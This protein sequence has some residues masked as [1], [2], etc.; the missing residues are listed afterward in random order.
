[1]TLV[2]LGFAAGPATAQDAPPAAPPPATTRVETRAVRPGEFM[3]IEPP[4]TAPSVPPLEIPG[5]LAP[6]AP[7]GR[8]TLTPS[9]GV[10]LEYDDNIFRN[11]DNKESDLI[12]G[13]SPGIALFINQPRYQIRASYGFTA[14]VYADHSELNEAFAQ[15]SLSAEGLYLLDPGLTL[16]LSNRFLY[17]TRGRDLGG[18]EDLQ[19]TSRRPVLTNRLEPA[20][21][22][23][24]R[25][26]T[27]LQLSG[28][29]TIQRIEAET[30]D[31]TIGED[32]AGARDSDSYRI[33]L[34]VTHTFRPRLRGTAGYEFAF[35]DTEE[36]PEVFTHTP[37][38]GLAYDF[39]RALRG[40]VSAGPEFVIR[41]SDTTVGLA[42][43]ASLVHAFR[44]GA[45]SAAYDQ[46]TRAQGGTGGPGRT[47]AVTASVLVTQWVRG[48]SLSLTPRYSLSDETGADRETRTLSVSLDASYEIWRNV[49][50]F[51]TYSFL[52]QRN[53]G[54][55]VRDVDQ[56]RVLLGIRYGYPISFD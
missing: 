49:S 15:Q 47:H 38:A 55:A 1:M 22:W 30:D 25:P 45:I 13:F 10:S 5:L 35:L 32:D 20:L 27:S 43:T 2:L 3:V 14:E 46:S 54:T 48:L 44:W 28:S 36:T 24:I 6:P 18:E 33:G 21:S 12:T 4:V 7:R 16:S 42:L 37:R 26:L 51:G 53:E 8:L 39:T 52:Q 19:R 56:N 11:N 23:Q 50:V 34:G 9:I 31:P 29:W 17:S 41:D 40:S